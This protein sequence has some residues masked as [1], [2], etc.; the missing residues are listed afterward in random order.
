[1]TLTP[2]P[3]VTA[4]ADGS[5]RRLTAI[6]I[7][8]GISSLSNVLV[9]LLAA[10]VLGVES[11]GLFLVVSLTY[12]ATQGFARA[13]VGEPLLVRPKE[14]HERPGEAI[15]SALVL[16]VGIGALVG[17]V[18]L[19]V[20]VGNHD[21][22][23]G[24]IALGLFLPFMI[25]QDLGRYLAV[26]TQQP[27]R[28]LVLD[29]VWLGLEVLA[30]GVLV[31]VDAETLTWFVV[32]WAGSGA[33]AS[34]VLLWQHRAHRIRPTLG[35]LRETW[36]FSWRYAS[37]FAARQG[38]G[39]ASVSLAGAALGAR[40]LAAFSGALTLFGPQVQ[41]Q[42][43]AMA[44]ATSE[45]ARL[46]AGNA[47]IDRHVRRTTLITGGAAAVNMV[48]LLVLP[49]RLGRLILDDVWEGTQTVLWPAGVQMLCIGLMSGVRAGLVGMRAVR[50]TLRLDIF[51]TV[52]VVLATTSAA[53]VFSVRGT[54]WTMAV[55]QAGLAVIWWTAYRR[56]MRR[57]EPVDP[58]VPATT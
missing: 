35:W 26:A 54:Y 46:P 4:T 47:A 14:S 33:A 29:L 34:G 38:A 22:G 25:V 40:A 23:G 11:F 45:V 5:G 51:Q 39:L 6:T 27:S 7:D 17:T 13:L 58:V 21:L 31:L 2:E 44:A 42:A 53:Q 19:A 49:D 3:P 24:L 10:R 30:V 8:Q 57:G 1:V 9:A 16:G 15:G 20:S 48:V 50:T 55:A 41:L 28:A 37:S 43:A 32:A 18:G 56:H 52:V 36:P 12:I